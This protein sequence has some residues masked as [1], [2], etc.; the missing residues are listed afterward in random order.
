MTDEPR[1]RAS[2]DGDE[3]A[4]R[5]IHRQMIEAW[6]RGSAE[7]FAAAFTDDADFIAFEGTHLSGHAQ[8][9]AFHRKIF[10]TVVKGSRLE[11][12]VKFVHFLGPR[13][14]L[15]HS[16]VRTTLAG[17]TAPFPGRDSMQ[18]YVIVKHDEGWRAEGL[19]NA[20]RLTLDQQ[21]FWDDLDSLSADGRRQ[22]THLV[23]SLLKRPAPKG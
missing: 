7:G 4:I 19:L 22:V 6:N 11:G 16:T 8:I 18:L 12:E 17:N 10:D 1:A 21:Y 20:R 13:L 14:A 2:R 9:V 3:A 15:M 5:A 23:A